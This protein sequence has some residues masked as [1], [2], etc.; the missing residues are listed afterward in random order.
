MKRDRHLSHVL[1]MNYMEA[2]SIPAEHV[3]VAFGV[4][5]LF[6]VEERNLFKFEY[7]AVGI[8]RGKSD[9]M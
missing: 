5:S 4:A 2:D 9:D 1:A 3:H 6:E 7:G 8:C